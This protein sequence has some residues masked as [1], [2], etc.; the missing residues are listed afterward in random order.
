MPEKWETGDRHGRKGGYKVRPS[1]HLTFLW[2]YRRLCHRGL[3]YDLVREIMID[4]HGSIN[5]AWIA[6]VNI[7]SG[8]WVTWRRYRRNK[9]RGGALARLAHTL[10]PFSVVW[11]LLHHV[12]SSSFCRAPTAVLPDN[13]HW[14]LATFTAH[15]KH[16][17]I[18]P[19]S[20]HILSSQILPGLQ[21]PG[22]SLYVLL[23]TYTRRLI[24]PLQ[25][26]VTIQYSRTHAA[27]H[28]THKNAKRKKTIKTRI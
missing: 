8:P 28:C 24:Y 9:S 11:S 21:D 10:A 17:W 25:L 22:S 1:A 7:E 27:L 4:E 23:L 20:A 26:N 15:P 12:F 16:S 6:G 2:P 3:R 13:G 19:A 18:Q 14:Q 5:H